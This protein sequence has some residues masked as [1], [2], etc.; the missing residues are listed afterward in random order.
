MAWH[1]PTQVFREISLVSLER[2]IHAPAAGYIHD[3]RK[4]GDIVQKGDEIAR[5]YPDKESYDNA[6]SEYVPV[7]ATITGIIRGLI[8]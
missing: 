2:V 7:N 5:I 8:R 1:S 3:V 6:L 4:I